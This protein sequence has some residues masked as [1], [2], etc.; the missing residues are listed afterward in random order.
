[1]SSPLRQMADD[2]A[3]DNDRIRQYAAAGWILGFVGGPLPAVFAFAVARP[4]AW[5]RRYSVAAA[6]YWTIAWLLIFGSLAL[7]VR[8]DRQWPFAVTIGVIL[9]SL[10]VVAAAAHRAAAR[11]ERE[12]GDWSS[13]IG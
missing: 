5:S 8:W 11:S 1:M 7:A 2:Q 12:G 3:V 10:V 6:V 9:I 4:G 13:L